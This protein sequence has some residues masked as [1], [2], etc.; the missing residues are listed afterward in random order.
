[1]FLQLYSVYISRMKIEDLIK[2]KKFRDEYER[3]EVNLVYTATFY[4]ARFSAFL[5]P[6]GISPQ[7]FNI[8]R[9]LRGQHP[10]TIPLK[11]ISERMLDKNSNTSR[12]IEKMRKK[13]L[14]TRETCPNNRRQVDIA[15]TEK[16]L[17]LVMNLTKLLNTDRSSYIHLSKEEALLLGNLLDK[18]RG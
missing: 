3:L 16:G 10:S 11:A 4:E 9:I 15:I 5:K 8:L 7:Q 12:L 2:Q 18:M 6:Y 13:Q 1:M 14:I 17:E